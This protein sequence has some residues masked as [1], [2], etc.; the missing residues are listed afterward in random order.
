MALLSRSGLRVGDGVDDNASL[1]W[2]L[3]RRTA[4]LT[5][6]WAVL[7]EGRLSDLPVGLVLAAAIALYSLR[8]NPPRHGRARLRPLA[9]L[10]LAP[11]VAWL[12]LAG[13][14]DVA[15]RAVRRPLDLDPDT[16]AYP[17]SPPS[18]PVAAA[19]AAVLTLVPGTLAVE[20]SGRRLLVHVLDRRQPVEEQFRRLEDGLRRGLGEAPRDGRAAP[21]RWGVDHA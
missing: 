7:V 5:G 6:V 8:L 4:L 1:M 16:V 9:L 19:L 3:A 21:P 18:V 17:L 11:W 10:A 13:G 14:V 2:T 20:V 12:A 15:R